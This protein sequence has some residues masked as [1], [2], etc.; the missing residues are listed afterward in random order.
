[1][2]L[3]DRRIVG[4]L[5]C[6]TI[7]LLLCAAAPMA[8]QQGID[9]LDPEQVLRGASPRGTV[10]V[11]AEA[12][13]GPVGVGRASHETVTI[14]Y[15][16][17]EFENWEEDGQ[18]LIRPFGSTFEV[19][20]RFEVEADSEVTQVRVCFL[21][22]ETTVNGPRFTEFKLYFYNDVNDGTGSA[23]VFNPFRQSGLVYN[24][25]ESLRRAGDSE[26]FRLTGDI[27]G[28]DLDR[29][30]HWVVVE[31][32]TANERVLGEDHY[33]EDDKAETGRGDVID[34]V[35]EVRY[36]T[37]PRAGDAVNRGWIDPRS[38]NRPT[39]TSGLKAV[40]IRVVVAPTHDEEPDPGDMD[41]DDEPDPEP[42]PEPED[43]VG[44]HGPL[45]APPTGP[46]HTNCLPT[47]APV[48]FEG[49]YR[50]SLCFETPA[51]KVG[52][53]RGGIYKSKQSGL[54]W[55]FDS[56]NAEVLI[57]VL[58]GCKETGHRW[59][60]MAAATDLAFNLYV[61]DGKNTPWRFHNRQ[62][63]AAATQ[64]DNMALKC[65]P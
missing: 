6:L 46:G 7:P 4:R 24:V 54:L 51:G 55:F 8:A 60:Y 52:H 14:R 28:K 59:V 34:H 50:V 56:D 17:G 33:T 37:T 36:R 20:Q 30:K 26:C 23:P 19:A 10:T 47:K 12:D 15:D 65:T 64:T 58:D 45:P 31:W 16:D 9:L 18:S 22:P 40:G 11:Q 41:D 29:D 62:G 61:T 21:R 2:K 25:D 42:E 1:M 32:S 5:I 3:T 49:D 53:A 35:T 13:E 43:D 27:V 39:T 63:E 44:P 48:V 57:K 38:A